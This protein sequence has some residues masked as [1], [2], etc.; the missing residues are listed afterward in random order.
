MRVHLFKLITLACII[1]QTNAVAF[2]NN[3]YKS[4]DLLRS[5]R[6]FWQ[7][8]DIYHTFYT[9]MTSDDSSFQLFE[10][11]SVIL[12]CSEKDT[13]STWML[14]LLELHFYIAWSRVMGDVVNRDQHYAVSYSYRQQISTTI[15]VLCPCYTMVHVCSGRKYYSYQNFRNLWLTSTVPKI[16][17]SYFFLQ[18]NLRVYVLNISFVYI[19]GSQATG[20][21]VINLQIQ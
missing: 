4:V 5:L 9:H 12:V 8:N 19:R 1:S 14:M 15:H 3:G 20:R 16:I 10:P 7:K 18:I 6:L 21:P 2:Y 13:C 11:I 17:N